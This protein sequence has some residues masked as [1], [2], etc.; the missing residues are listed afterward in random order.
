MQ[1]RDSNKQA[2]FII[3][4]F[5]FYPSFLLSRNFQHL[6]G[7]YAI[8]LFLQSLS[9][10]LFVVLRSASVRQP[11]QGSVKERNKAEL[12][13]PHGGDLT[14]A[15]AWRQQRPEAAKAKRERS[16]E[17][18]DGGCRPIVGLLCHLRS[19]SGVHAHT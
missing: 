3:I 18:E 19:V 17:A 6:R 10:S 11:R 5:F 9:G 14:A 7:L 12:G 8:V 1:L 4:F 13:A 2:T 16:R 15:S